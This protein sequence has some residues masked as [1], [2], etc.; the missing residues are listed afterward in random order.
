MAG[1][2]NPLQQVKKRISTAGAYA[3]SE[4]QMK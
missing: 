2:P 3:F 1:I 4:L